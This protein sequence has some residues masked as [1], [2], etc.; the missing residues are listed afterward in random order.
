[1]ADRARPLRHADVEQLE[2][3][4]LQAVLAH[5]VGDRHQVARHLER[6]GAHLRVRQV[7]LH[8]HLRRARVGDVDRGEVLRRALVRQPQDAAAVLRQL[9]AHALAH[10]AEAVE[11]VLRQ[12]LH[13]LDHGPKI[14]QF[15]AGR[16]S[17][18]AEA[19]TPR[20]RSRNFCTLPFSVRGRSSTTSTI[21]A[22][23]R[24]TAG[25]PRRSAASAA[26]SS[27]QPGLGRSPPSPR[28]PPAPSAP[29]RPPPPRRR[30]ARAAPAPPRRRRCS[31]RAAGSQSFS[32]SMKRNAPSASRAT[33]SPVWNQ[34]SRQASAVFSGMPK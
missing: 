27:R 8:D 25:G 2:A 6:V 28:P 16:G 29:G 13:V 3:G 34:P 24:S 33:R 12:Q 1:M 20:S 14:N 11:G 17:R 26:A 5:L 19:V 4:G 31:P 10:A 21:A 7:G 15:R 22:G 23:P 30:V 32:R 9:Q 18:I